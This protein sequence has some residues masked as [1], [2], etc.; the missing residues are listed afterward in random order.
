M[1]NAILC[2][3]PFRMFFTIGLALFLAPLVARALDN[4]TSSADLDCGDADKAKACL[5]CGCTL[6]NLCIICCPLVGPCTIVNKPQATFTPIHLLA[7]AEGM[8]LEYSRS[9]GDERGVDI[10]LSATYLPQVFNGPVKV[11]AHLTGADAKF[12]ALL[13]PVLYLG[14]GTDALTTLQSHGYDV[15]VSLSGTFATCQQMYGTQ[16]S[17]VCPQLANSL[18]KSIAGQLQ[19]AGPSESDA[20][21]SGVNDLGYG[22]CGVFVP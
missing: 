3:S 18:S 10:D 16:A 13:Y 20:F 17:V 7:M 14:S 8:A 5:E 2:S 19:A 9:G 21:L 22:L 6:P 15:Q 4:V 1:S 12:A 11:R